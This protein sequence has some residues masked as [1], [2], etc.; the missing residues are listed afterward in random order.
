VLSRRPLAVGDMVRAVVTGAE[1]A[2]LVAEVTGDPPADGGRPISPGTDA[3]HI[4]P[5]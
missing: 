1:G 4:E 3:G 2:D 5:A